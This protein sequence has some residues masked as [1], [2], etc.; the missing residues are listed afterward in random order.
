MRA[1]PGVRRALR[2]WSV[3]IS[4]F[5]LDLGMLYVATSF[6]G[7]SYLFATPVSFLIAVSINYTISRKVAFSETERPWRAGYAYFIG[8][9]I[10]GAVAT[11]AIVAFLVTY[12]GLFFLVARVIASFFV[13]IGNYLFNLYIN[14]KVAGVHQK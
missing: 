2:Y 3:G 4:T 7:V 12:A 11:T 6:L 9:A 5:G 1:Y 10:A 8:F 13:G 14:F